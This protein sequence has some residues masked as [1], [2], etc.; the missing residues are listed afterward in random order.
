[1]PKLKTNVFQNPI[2]NEFAYTVLWESSLSERRGLSGRFLRAASSA[3]A[4][5]AFIKSASMEDKLTLLSHFGIQNFL[6]LCKSDAV[7]LKDL[8]TLLTQYESNKEV[9]SMEDI[10][11]M[12][13]FVS[14]DKQ[15][16][17]LLGLMSQSIF[18]NNFFLN[19]EHKR[20]G[21]SIKKW[22]KRLL[23]STDLEVREV[24]EMN[25]LV[26][27]TIL[28]STIRVKYIKGLTGLTEEAMQVLMYLYSNQHTF[29]KRDTIQDYFTGSISATKMNYSLK[30]L[31]KNMYVT[32]HVNRSE[33]SVTI[34][35]NGVKAVSTF[36]D[37]II[38]L[39]S[40]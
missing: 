14:S 35:A 9:K 11:S 19:L 39:N 32:E 1:M 25:N 23:S 5:K 16:N 29:V 40:F 7:N 22:N 12:G 34:S 26:V 20:L 13:I 2:F 15:F 31:V 33:G 24:M 28:N 27:R 18:H 36:V 17:H 6:V 3:K 37:S 21:Y 30:A 4:A 8:K 38:K 10:A